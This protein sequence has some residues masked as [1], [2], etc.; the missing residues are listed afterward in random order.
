MIRANRPAFTL[1]ELLC[2]IGLL[3]VIGLVLALMLKETI[4]LERAQSASFDA[5][6]QRNALADQFRA[7]VAL[8]EKTLPAWDGYKSGPD[9]LILEASKDRHVVYTWHEGTLTR[10]ERVG[11]EDQERT[12][13]IAGDTAVE[14]DRTG[15]LVRLK[16][17]HT[18]AGKAAP[19][20]TVEIAAA[21]AGDAP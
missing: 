11:K 20:R 8:A 15:K 7:D 4:D 9:I 21:L 10:S 1:V 2:V 12:L 5:M 18:P 14:F 13:P 19:G 3:G 16:L 17:I 6:L